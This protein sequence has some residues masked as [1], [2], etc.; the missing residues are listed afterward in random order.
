M[1]KTVTVL[2]AADIHQRKPL[3]DE[4]ERAVKRHR[5]DIVALVGDFLDAGDRCA[6]RF[7]ATECAEHL[8]RLASP[9]VVFVRGNHEEDAWQAFAAAWNGTGRQLNAL[10][11]EMF[12]HGPMVLVGF[13]C[14]LGDETSYLGPR[15][16]L[17][18][19][20]TEWLLSLL[21]AR[22]SAMRT[23]WLMHEPPA[24]TPLSETDGPLAGNPEWIEA[25]ERFEPWLMIF[26][27][28]H[29]TPVRRNRWHFNIGRTQCVNVGQSDT[30]LLHYCLVQ[31][32]FPKS[33]PCLPT[34]LQVTAFPWRKTICCP[35]PP[36]SSPSPNT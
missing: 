19:D 27:H 9:H 18:A 14:L 6:G 29:E 5:P 13:P 17:P 11:G 1:S 30:G 31:A 23:L 36:R 33:T 8:S 16:S 24:G 34:T 15:Q 21:R 28:D 12:V 20:A 10:H 2:T 3:Y 4:L 22:G 32:E 7:T 26:G 35:K 25:I